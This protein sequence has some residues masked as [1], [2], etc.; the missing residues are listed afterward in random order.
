MSLIPV[1]A[2][3]AQEPSVQAH[4]QAVAANFR[5]LAGQLRNSRPLAEL[6]PTATLADV[7]AALN[8]IIRRLAS[9]EG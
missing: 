9:G 3:A 2:A 6:P 8:I 4:M 1:E 7:I 5:A